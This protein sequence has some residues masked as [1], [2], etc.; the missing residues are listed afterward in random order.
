MTA[1]V[2]VHSMS[3]ATH[4]TQQNAR[5]AMFWWHLLRKHPSY[6]RRDTSGID[7]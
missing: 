1:R 6:A 4:S 7:C 5:A 2:C 3:L